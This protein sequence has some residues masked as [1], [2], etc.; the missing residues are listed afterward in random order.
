MLL[1]MLIIFNDYDDNNDDDNDDSND[2][3]NDSNDKTVIC[4]E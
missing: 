4:K 1:N 3:D 2:N